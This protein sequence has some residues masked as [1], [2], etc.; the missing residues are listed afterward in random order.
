MNTLIDPVKR[1]ARD[2]VDK[3]L[4][5]VAVLL[6][7]ALVAVPILIGGGS[8][9]DDAAAPVAIA[10]PEPGAPGSKS[11]ITVADETDGGEDTRPGRIKDP[12]Y[13]PP[14]PP[15]AETGSSTSAAPAGSAGASTGASTPG[16]TTQGGT[17][18]AQ[19]TEP[20]QTT[21]RPPADP[22]AAPSYYRTEVRWYE[23][24]K[25]KARPIARLTPFGGVEDP[26][27]LYLGVT[28]SDAS[29]AVFLLAPK[30]TSTGDAECEKADCRV[31]GLKAGQSQVVTMQPADGSATRTYNL[32]VVSVKA[33]TTA[34]AEAREKRADIHPDGRDVMR[35]MWQHR[36][37]AEALQPI[38]YD[39]DSGLLFK[40]AAAAKEPS[41]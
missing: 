9:A 13:D 8:S 5:P 40:S 22:V 24:T 36:L 7:A 11:L 19:P 10:A 31:I 29:Y 33:V 20:S 41:E 27:A 1:I 23:T 39:Q 6:L 17:P 14:E 4:W 2:L 12:F 18:P 21:P 26:A 32:D 25:V 35:A 3:K 37:T 38:Q 16:G 28:R 34:A 30:A 15:A